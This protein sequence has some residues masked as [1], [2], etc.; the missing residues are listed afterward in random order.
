MISSEKIKNETKKP[1][2][3]FDSSGVQDMQQCARH[4]YF[5][6]CPLA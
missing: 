1:P 4:F 3:I 2:K 5:L 6:L